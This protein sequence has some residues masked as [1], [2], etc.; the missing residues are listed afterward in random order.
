MADTPSPTPSG[1]R[2]RRWARR[3]ALAALILA[4]VGAGFVTTVAAVYRSGFGARAEGERLARMQSSPQWT[5]EAFENPQP[6][7][8]ETSLTAMLRA[9]WNKSAHAVPDED[10]PL[11][12]IHDLAQA[13]EPLAEDGLRI[14]WLGHSTML[15]ELGDTVL[16]TDPV[17]GE[18]TSPIPWLGPERWYAPPVALDALPELDAIVLSHDHYDHLDE[19]TMRAFA[20][21]TVPIFAPLGLGAHLELWGIPPDRIHELDWWESA[22]VGPVTLTCTPSR[23]ASG[24]IGLDYNA[25]L[26]AGWAMQSAEHRVFFSGDTGLFDGLQEIGERLGPFDVTMIE[27]GAYDAMWPDW[28]LGPEQAVIAHQWVRGEVMLPVH[29]GLFDLA[30]HSW[31]EPIQRTAAA[32]ATAGVQLVTP[33]PGGSFT[34][35]DTLPDARWWPSS[36]PWRSAAE[37]PVVATDTNG[38]PARVD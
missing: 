25:T 22:P 17:W 9:Y 20:E 12:V 21:S 24:R 8:L 14:T 7:W 33:P 26:W 38:A 32:A 35:G 18:R 11:P 2:F 30:L 16:L 10:R 29:W 37:A 36:V 1:G 3:L 23:H 34:L 15:I 4:L 13:S 19:P 5:G 27:V 28:H 31:T 6:L